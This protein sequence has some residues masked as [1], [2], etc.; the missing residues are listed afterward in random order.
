[1]RFVRGFRLNAHFRIFFIAIIALDC[2]AHNIKI[3]VA[4]AFA[5][6]TAMKD[7]GHKSYYRSRAHLK[8]RFNFV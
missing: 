7:V 6:L 2:S 1:M 5:A 3:K 8:Y 4:A